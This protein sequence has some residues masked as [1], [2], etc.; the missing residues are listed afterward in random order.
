MFSKFTPA[1]LALAALAVSPAAARADIIV[2]RAAGASASAVR[3]DAGVQLVEHLPLARTEVVKAAPG[4][5]A[6]ALAQL[7]ADPSVVYAE[8][9]GAM[10]ALTTD[11]YFGY[12]WALSNDGNGPYGGIAGDDV[13]ALQAWTLSRGTGET[14]AVVDTGVD[15]THEDL[16]GQIATGGWDFVD[17]DG[18]PSDEHGHGTHVAGI[19]AAAGDKGLGI[20]G[21]APGAKVMPLRVLDAGGWG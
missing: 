10:H 4:D 3:S 18:D 16:T 9:D 2:Q 21:V 8:P 1:A 12:Q 15:F 17:G 7:N 5:Q 20:S 19:I 11:A 14:V 6:E 13:H